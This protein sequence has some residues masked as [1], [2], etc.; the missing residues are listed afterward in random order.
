MDN[1][2]SIFKE[3]K[4]HKLSRLA[5]YLIVGVLLLLAGLGWSQV[6]RSA[7]P[8]LA[9]KQ[10]GQSINVT[11]DVNARWYWKKSATELSCNADLASNYRKHTGFGLSLTDSGSKIAYYCVQAEDPTD[12]TPVRRNLPIKFYP[13]PT[14]TISQN[15]NDIIATASSEVEEGTPSW[16]HQ[17]TVS[18]T[19]CNT[20]TLSNS[21]SWQNANSVATPTTNPK[22]LPVAHGQSGGNYHCFLFKDKNSG[23]NYAAQWVAKK[24]TYRAPAT[25]DINQNGK[26]ISASVSGSYQAIVY[27]VLAENNADCDRTT[28]FTGAGYGVGTNYTAVDA[29]DDKVICFRIESN[30]ASGHQVGTYS[31]QPYTIDLTPP[32]IHVA[33]DI[34]TPHLTASSSNNLTHWQYRIATS[35]ICGSGGTT[36]YTSVSSRVD[37]EPTVAKTSFSTQA[38]DNLRHDDYVCFKAKNERGIWGAGQTKYDQASQNHRISV[39]QGSI[40]QT[41]TTGLIYTSNKT[42]TTWKYI[43]VANDLVDC[44]TGPNWTTAT[45]GQLVTLLPSFHNQTYCFEAIYTDTV[46]VQ[47]KAYGQVTI[48][49]VAP[50]VA[51]SQDTKTIT[52]QTSATDVVDA[53]WQYTTQLTLRADCNSHIGASKWSVAS[54]DNKLVKKSA[55]SGYSSLICFRVK[56]NVG[57]YGYEWLEISQ[58]KTDDP[59]KK[60]DL[61]IT[62][63]Q[64]GAQFSYSANR[65]VANWRYV[66]PIANNP[67]CSLMNYPTANGQVTSLK[68]SD[69]NQYYCVRGQDYNRQYDYAKIYVTGIATPT[70]PAPIIDVSFAEDIMIADVTNK[71]GPITWRYFIDDNSTNCRPDYVGWNNQSDYVGNQSISISTIGQ[72]NRWVCLRAT[73]SSSQTGHLTKRVDNQKTLSITIS[74]QK[75]QLTASIPGD[76]QQV[77]WRYFI[78]GTNHSCRAD[79][80][81]WNRLNDIVGKTTLNIPITVDD[82]FDW[83]CVRATDASKNT[84]VQ[85]YKI[86]PVATVRQPSKPTISFNQS[87]TQLVANADQTITSWRYLIF[88]KK[89]TT[90]NVNNRHFATNKAGKTNVAPLTSKTEGY[91]YCFKAVSADDTVG[92]ALWQVTGIAGPITP[93]V[94]QP[95]TPTTPTTPPVQPPPT[96]DEDD[97]KDEDSD[98]QKDEEDQTVT[99][100]TDTDSSMPTPED[101]EPKDDDNWL[102]WYLVGGG[103]GLILVIIIVEMIGSKKKKQSPDQDSG[104]VGGNL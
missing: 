3:I 7:T 104:A 51:L 80:T 86:S 39:K 96:Q 72:H 20:Q 97:Q 71:K 40:G 34:D 17:Q 1:L 102:I 26:E 36:P 99:T 5:I 61:E 70:A 45:D 9:W 6:A 42:G 15:G 16:Y 68:A 77:N 79:Y 48:D 94:T 56:D 13:S 10:T 75:Y 62:V 83:V 43:N 4:N 24:Y 2:S 21:T 84:G 67:D 53:S 57:N 89:P 74:Q 22:T 28:E 49:L 101:D 85:P 63:R 37:S 41:Y 100:P 59:D 47:H 14:L 81:G 69:N 60:T 8:N 54:A 30:P 92:V 23:A 76:D 93:P 87:Q 31:Y 95:T 50:V 82:A 33:H 73:D 52:A 91:Y 12:D 98:D 88:N 29:N 46:D 90:C 18:S 32:T 35:E 58:Q 19:S 27:K 78:A 25:V 55:L 65:A 64:K 66:G 38:A 103:A 44:Q 11:S